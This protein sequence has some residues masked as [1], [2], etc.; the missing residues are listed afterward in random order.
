MERFRCYY[1][2]DHTENKFSIIISHLAKEH[3]TLCVKHRE[4]ELQEETGR[5][6]YITI[7]YENVI[8]QDGELFVTEDEKGGYRKGFANI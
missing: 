2:E 6:G 1:Y 4:P 3:V 8:P 5:I 7:C